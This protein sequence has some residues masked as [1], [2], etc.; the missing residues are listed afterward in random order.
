M[1]YFKTV[2][3]INIGDDDDPYFADLTIN[4]MLLLLY[5]A[6]INDQFDSNIIKWLKSIGGGIKHAHLCDR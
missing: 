6:I 3:L 1:L 4:I 5:T 2:G